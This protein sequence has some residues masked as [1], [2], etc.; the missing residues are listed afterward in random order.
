MQTR[1]NVILK[2]KHCKYSLST[3]IRRLYFLVPSILIHR[4][5][6]ENN[7]VIQSL[8]TQLE[9][10]RAKIQLLEVELQRLRGIFL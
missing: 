8:R 3:F 1:T 6:T 7:D 2:G 10:A 4:V 5:F 9:E